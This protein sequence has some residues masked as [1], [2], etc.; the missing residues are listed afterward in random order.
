MGWLNQSDFDHMKKLVREMTEEERRSLT[1]E[2]ARYYVLPD[3]MELATW[4]GLCD[5][6]QGTPFQALALL[7]GVGVNE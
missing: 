6:K 3:T 1:W 5:R 7:R 4:S 2:E